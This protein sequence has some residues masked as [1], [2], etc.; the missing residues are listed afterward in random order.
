[1]KWGGA[2]TITDFLGETMTTKK[3]FNF[4][5][6]RGFC[7]ALLFIPLIVAGGRLVTRVVMNLWNMFES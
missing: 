6:Q 7:T 3:R 2:A 5:V 4:F 1:M